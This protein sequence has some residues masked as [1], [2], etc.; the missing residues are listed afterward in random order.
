MRMGLGGMHQDALRR[1]GISTFYIRFHSQK[2]CLC[3]H[4]NYHGQKL[5]TKV[6]IIFV[7]P[8]SNHDK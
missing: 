1:V 2:G 4:A 8:Y 6:H 5:S 7:H 3:T